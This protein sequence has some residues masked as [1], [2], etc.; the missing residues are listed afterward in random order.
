LNASQV[1]SF[2]STFKLTGSLNV[3]QPFWR[4]VFL[5]SPLEKPDPLVL[6]SQPETPVIA[7]LRRETIFRYRDE[8]PSHLLSDNFTFLYH[9]RGK[10]FRSSTL[11][12]F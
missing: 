10:L 11:F 6:V 3:S 4:E 12:R 7:Q 5:E 8:T 9:L 1:D 2:P